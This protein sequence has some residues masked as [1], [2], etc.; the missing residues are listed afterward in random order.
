MSENTDVLNTNSINHSINTRPGVT[1]QKVSD[2]LGL[3]SGLAGTWVGTGFSLVELPDFDSTFPSTGPA[4]FRLKLNKT[5][6]TLQFT[7]VGG[8]VPNRGVITSLADLTKGQPDIQ[9]NALS[10]LQRISDFVTNEPLHIEPGFWLN[11]PPTTVFPVQSATTVARLATIPHGDAV[12]ALGVPFSVP[13]GPVIAAADAS[14]IRLSDKARLI[15]TPGYNTP[16]LNPPLPPDFKLS[17]VANP[18]LALQDA[19]LGQKI[20]NTVVLIITTTSESVSIPSS[21]NATDPNPPGTVVNIAA[22]KG[23]S[24]SVP[25]PGGGTV[26]S[27]IVNIPFVVQNANAVTLDAIFWIETVQQPDGS[28]FLQLQYTQTIFLQFLGI[29]WPHITVATLVKQ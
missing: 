6:E 12:S 28:T 4:P 13:S 22:P 25:A 18:N 23:G 21:A 29:N 26:N 24:V 19:I 9:L 8:T 17:Y 5:I 27:S 7:P 3:L 1:L 2:S 10:Y 16:F 15:D 20:I 11:V 14:P